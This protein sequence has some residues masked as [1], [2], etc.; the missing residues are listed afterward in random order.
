MMRKRA[1]GQVY[2]RALDPDQVSG[3]E[4]S[5]SQT[6][7]VGWTWIEKHQEVVTSPS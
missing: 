4:E 6:G 1:L 5:W 2:P 7:L 3:M